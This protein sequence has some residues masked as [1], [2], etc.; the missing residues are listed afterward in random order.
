MLYYKKRQRYCYAIVALLILIFIIPTYYKS[1][2]EDYKIDVV[3]ICWE[4]IL[5]NSIQE[6][7]T[8]LLN[9][10]EQ[11][12]GKS[13]YVIDNNEIKYLYEF[14]PFTI[15]EKQ[16]DDLSLLIN[17]YDMNLLLR[18]GGHFHYDGF[19]IYP[20][21]YYR[22]TIYTGTTNYIITYDS[23]IL[24]AES[25]EVTSLRNLHLFLEEMV[26]Q[27]EGYDELLSDYRD[28]PSPF[29]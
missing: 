23:S 8:V 1:K 27:A 25:G 5:G 19:Q 2:E 4:S 6:N 3:D 14:M 20:P 28:S 22:V 21:S 17:K 11:I 9:T 18:R 26:T 7:M 16:Y 15:N 12:I 13:Q 24:G 29:Y 10:K